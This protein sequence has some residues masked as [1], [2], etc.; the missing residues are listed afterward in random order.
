M[1]LWVN[2]HSS[3]SDTTDSTPAVGLVILIFE[4]LM[5]IFPISWTDHIAYSVVIHKWLICYNYLA[6]PKSHCV[7]ASSHSS[8]Y[9]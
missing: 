7:N 3:K 1:A 6:E 2:N 8:K 4:I 9:I 5:F